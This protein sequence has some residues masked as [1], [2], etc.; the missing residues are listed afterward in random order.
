MPKQLNNKRI[1]L[2]ISELTYFLEHND[3]SN[4]I[5]N[6]ED[7]IQ[8]MNKN[9]RVKQINRMKPIV[10]YQSNNLKLE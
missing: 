10:D 6:I 1:T 2:G 8:Y 9:H 7:P 5:I 4:N 3:E